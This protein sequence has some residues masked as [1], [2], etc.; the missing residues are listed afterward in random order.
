M[1][2]GNLSAQVLG[3]DDPKSEGREKKL[4]MLLN[5]SLAAHYS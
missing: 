2:D 1:A 5:S 3:L 4:E